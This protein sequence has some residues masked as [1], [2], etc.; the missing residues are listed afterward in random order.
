[1]VL[2]SFLAC[3]NRSD[4][5]AI[6]KKNIEPLNQ[7]AGILEDKKAL[8]LELYTHLLEDD[9]LST[10]EFN[11]LFGDVYNEANRYLI[12]TLDGSDTENSYC[13]EISETCESLIFNILKQHIDEIALNNELSIIKESLKIATWDKEKLTLRLPNENEVDFYF[14]K[15]DGFNGY[16]NIIT[17]IISK[18]RSYLRYFEE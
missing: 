11:Q 15:A 16:G 12:K 13:G 6:A 9:F 7:N 3:T 5:K 18:N 14:K 10:L 17:N 1:M 2:L 4:K 8:V